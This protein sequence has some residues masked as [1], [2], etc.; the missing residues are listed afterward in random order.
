MIKYNGPLFISINKPFFALN[1]I[2]TMTAS[3]DQNISIFRTSGV[4]KGRREREWGGRSRRG[5]GERVRRREGMED[6]R[7]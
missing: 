5:D 6:D 2:T 4:G 7:R 3:Y 1:A